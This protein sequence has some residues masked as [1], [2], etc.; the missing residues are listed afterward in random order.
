MRGPFL[1]WCISEE[2]GSDGTNMPMVDFR[3]VVLLDR[4]LRKLG[5]TKE[6]SSFHSRTVGPL[7]V[8]RTCTILTRK[9]WGPVW[10]VNSKL[11]FVHAHVLSWIA[12]SSFRVLEI[13]VLISFEVS[14]LV[15][16]VLHGYDSFLWHF[17]NGLALADWNVGYLLLLPLTTSQLI[18]T[19]A[20]AFCCKKACASKATFRWS[21]FVHWRFL[22]SVNVST[23]LYNRN[24]FLFQVLE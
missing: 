7:Y 2:R 11:L 22:Q 24:S 8:I 10:S 19:A 21:V 9:A 5:R 4:I 18:A 16:Q 23:I 3:C 14:C 17:Y 20:A 15:G 1:I 13:H 6:H 12:L